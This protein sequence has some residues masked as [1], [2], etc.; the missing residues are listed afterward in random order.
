MFWLAEASEL[1]IMSVST[2]ISLGITYDIH[3]GRFAFEMHLAL[4]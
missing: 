2:K 1:L 3:P 4:Q